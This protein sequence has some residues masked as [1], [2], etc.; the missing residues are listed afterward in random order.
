MIPFCDFG[1]GKNGVVTAGDAGR[2]T[3]CYI[4]IGGVVSLAVPRR[5]VFILPVAVLS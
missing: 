5:I 3:T 2:E 4:M 1:V